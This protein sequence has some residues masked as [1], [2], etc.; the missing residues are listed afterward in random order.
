MLRLFDTLSLLSF[1]N[2]KV[3]QELT[4]PFTKRRLRDTTELAFTSTTKSWV[5][6]TLVGEI[7]PDPL[8][9]D[10]QS[11]FTNWRAKVTTT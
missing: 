11:D 3:V 2:I 9:L 1:H 7:I 5:I 4:A 10:G 8:H 6:I